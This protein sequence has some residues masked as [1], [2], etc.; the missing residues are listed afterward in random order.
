VLLMRVFVPFVFGFY[1]SYLYRVINA[2][3]APHLLSELHLDASGLGLLTSTYF[4]TFGACQLPVGALLDRFGPR[5]VQA[6]LMLVAALGAFVFAFGTSSWVLI[7][8]RGLIGIGVSAAWVGGLKATATW[9]PKERLSLVNGWMLALGSLGAVTATGPADMIVH[10]IGWRGLFAAL[11]AL[12]LLAGG[13]VFATVPDAAPATASVSARPS[14]RLRDICVDQD[15]LRIAPLWACAIGTAWAVQGLWVARWLTDVDGYDQHMIVTHLFVMACTLSAGGIVLGNLAHRLRQRGIST[16]T[17]FVSAIAL[18]MTI[19][20]LIVARA[21]LSS[22]ALWGAA[23]VFGSLT[24]L[25]FAIMSELY[26]KEIIGR[27]N[28]VIGALQ[29]AAG[30]FFQWVM[31]SLIA[32]WRPNAAGHYPTIAY[33]AAFAFPLLLQ[34]LAMGWFLWATMGRGI[35]RPVSLRYTGVWPPAA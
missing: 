34:A 1:L 8:G 7:A 21:P 22:Y 28:S 32:L 3:I 6:A 13:V 27:A 20:A 19:E 18:Y 4:L 25:G 9:F 30:F 35:A 26:P 16:V 29:I 10:L 14:V 5:R 17:V 15:F 33:Q 11:G 2:L 12:S 24:A 31:G 23:A